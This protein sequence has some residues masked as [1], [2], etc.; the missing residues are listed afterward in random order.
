M[1]PGY[2]KPQPAPGVSLLGALAL[3]VVCAGGAAT[4]WWL[5]WQYL[6]VSL[7]TAAAVAAVNGYLTRRRTAQ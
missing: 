7:F 6:A 1:N 3:V 4:V 5:N 2:S